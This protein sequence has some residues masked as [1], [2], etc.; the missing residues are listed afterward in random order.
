[1]TEIEWP[2]KN[3]TI[4][5][6][7]ALLWKRVGELFFVKRKKFEKSR[8]GYNLLIFVHIFM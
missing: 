7:L 6:W 3:L 5:R 8:R 4:S 1:M 2:E